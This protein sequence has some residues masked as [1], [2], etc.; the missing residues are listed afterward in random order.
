MIDA[1]KNF[2][3]VTVSAGY[4]AAATSI[5][6]TAGHGAR[7]PDTA[8][9]GSFNLVWWN[10]TDYANPSDDPNVEI[11][12]VTTRSTDTL[13]PIVRGEDG[14]SASTKNTG[15][16]TYKM[17]LAPTASLV[18]QIRKGFALALTK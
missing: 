14:T 13:N 5:A 3:I 1:V 10:S 11:V 8:V 9:D 17:M 18:K 6:L 2:A 12:R 7:L 16:K 4:D 15:G